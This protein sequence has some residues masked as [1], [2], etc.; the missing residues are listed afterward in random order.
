MYE[1]IISLGFSVLVVTRPHTDRILTHGHSA[2]G[3]DALIMVGDFNDRCV[4]WDDRHENYL[5]LHL[6]D[7]EFLLFLGGLSRTEL[8]RSKP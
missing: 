7:P 6:F 3:P 5:P 4:H 1:P 2:L 8:T